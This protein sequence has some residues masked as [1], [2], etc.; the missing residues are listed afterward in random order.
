MQSG[1]E[2]RF[3][4]S[5]SGTS[6]AGP[7]RARSCPGRSPPAPGWARPSWPAGSGEPHADPRGAAPAGRR[8]PGRAAAEPGRPGGHLV[9]PRSC[10]RSSSCGCVWSRTR[11][12]L[13]RARSSTAGQL[14]E[15]RRAGRTMMRI[16]KPGRTQDLDAIVE[17]NRRF[18]G[19]FIEAADAAPLRP[20]C[21]AVT[22]AAVVAPELPRLHP[23][24]AAPQP[25]T[26]TSRWS[27]PRGRATATGPRRSC[28]PTCYNAARRAPGQHASDGAA[29]MSRH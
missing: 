13:R 7:A 21:A 19:L 23:G 1:G 15:L 5:S 10:A 17:L 4:A 2:R 3:G 8:G 6:G 25:R 14:D 24:S 22:H 18:H 28:A 29:R 12:R 26:T 16:G 20:R 27:P 9:R 11:S